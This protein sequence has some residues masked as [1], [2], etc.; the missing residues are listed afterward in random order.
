[1]AFFRRDKVIELILSHGI[2]G[3]I[4][5]ESQKILSGTYF[6]SGTKILALLYK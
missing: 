3:N 5:F 1:M 6:R 2:V 4:A